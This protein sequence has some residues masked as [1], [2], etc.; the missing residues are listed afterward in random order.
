M[1]NIMRYS[2]Y[3]KYVGRW[4]NKLY[5]HDFIFAADR[6]IK[7]DSTHNANGKRQKNF[8]KEISYD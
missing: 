2:G 8:E 1:W 6:K 7:T 3:K 4:K 5:K